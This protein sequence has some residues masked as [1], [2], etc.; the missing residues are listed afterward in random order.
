[1][2]DPKT[3]AEYRYANALKWIRTVA[4]L[5]YFGGAFDPEHMRALAN[6]AGNDDD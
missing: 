3:D 1:V 4:G 2:T 6:L 5:H